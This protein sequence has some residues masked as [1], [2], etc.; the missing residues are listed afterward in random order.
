MLQNVLGCGVSEEINY[1]IVLNPSLLACAGVT[2]KNQKRF[3]ISTVVSIPVQCFGLKI[4]K[5]FGVED[6]DNY[7]KKCFIYSDILFRLNS[8]LETHPS[9]EN[10]VFTSNTNICK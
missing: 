4:V 10:H 1:K 2:T 3:A 8:F 9:R 5:K 6:T 7:S